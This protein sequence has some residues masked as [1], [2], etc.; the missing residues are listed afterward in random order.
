VQKNAIHW[1]NE[2]GRVSVTVINKAIISLI[3]SFYHFQKGRERFGHAQSSSIKLFLWLD[4][5][6]VWSVVESSMNYRCKNIIIALLPNV[7]KTFLCV[8]LI[9][10]SCLSFWEMAKNRHKITYSADGSLLISSKTF[11]IFWYYIELRANLFYMINEWV[12]CATLTCGPRGSRINKW[13]NE[14]S[15]NNHWCAYVSC[16]GELSWKNET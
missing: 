2:Q 8:I 11:F 14:L 4:P 3:L 10:N 16:V 6:N 12:T 15:R 5:S 1:E 13:I 9:S 7:V